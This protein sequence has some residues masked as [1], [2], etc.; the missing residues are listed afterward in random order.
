MEEWVNRRT[1]S[2]G[3]YIECRLIRCSSFEQGGSRK[4]SVGVKP[5][6]V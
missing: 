4:E 3:S 2:V 1:V 6:V 5:E